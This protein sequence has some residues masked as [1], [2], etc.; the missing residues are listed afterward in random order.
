MS[1]DVKNN[2]TIPLSHSA[3]KPMLCFL[4]LSMWSMISQSHSLSRSRALVLL[5][6][7]FHR[8]MASHLQE[9]IESPGHHIFLALPHLSRTLL[10]VF[11]LC[12]YWKLEKEARDWPRL[13]AL[14][15]KLSQN[16]LFERPTNQ[17]PPSAVWTEAVS[18]HSTQRDTKKFF[19]SLLF[20]P[21]KHIVLPKI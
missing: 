18:S 12:S 20:F 1:V 10:R 6:W 2:E 7:D 11:P 9:V 8:Q 21:A 5:Q 17:C 15:V 3:H 19:V 13:F 16:K 4:S 14:Q